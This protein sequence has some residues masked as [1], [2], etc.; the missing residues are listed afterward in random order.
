LYLNER[1]FIPPI[2]EQSRIVDFIENMLCRINDLIQKKQNII[3][4]LKEE[5]TAIIN[6]AVTKGLDPNV[7]MKDSGIEWLGEIPGHWKIIKLKRLGEIRYGLGQPP[8]TLDTG[9]PMIRATNISKGKIIENDLILVDPTDLPK[10]KDPYLKEGEIIIVRS[11]AYTGDSAI[12]PKKY[13]GAVSGYDIVFTPVS[14][15]SI[16]LSFSLLSNYVLNNQLIPSSMRA[17]QPHLNAEE[18]GATLIACSPSLNDQ[19]N[20]GVYL[21]EK[22][23]E[24]EKSI[25]LIQIEIELL[26]EYKISLINEAVT[27]KIDV[28][29][30]QF[31]NA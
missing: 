13:N 9:L 1:V 24:I 29:D 22:T 5:R 27:G 19:R 7:P 26:L 18:L 6:Q 25:A 2:S 10:G 21:V 31:N 17:A 14:C 15:D 23:K 12:I 8:R 11:G 16:F 30:Y 20:I 28:R 3:E 4:L